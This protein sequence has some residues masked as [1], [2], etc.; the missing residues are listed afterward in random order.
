MCTDGRAHS[1]V[2]FAG[3]VTWSTLVTSWL[4]LDGWFG[5]WAGEDA[6]FV[7]VIS[8]KVQ[9][10]RSWSLA[11]KCSLVQGWCRHVCAFAAIRYWRHYVFGLSVCPSLC[12]LHVYLSIPKLMS[13]SVYP[14]AKKPSRN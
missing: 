6:V 5:G 4:T 8:Q 11:C 7:R 12:T 10:A 1:I 14:S 9:N 13:A 3:T 2:P